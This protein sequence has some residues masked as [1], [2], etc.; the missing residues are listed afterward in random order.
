MVLLISCIDIAGLLLA[1]SA[2]RRREVATRLAISGSRGAMVEQL[3]V[4]VFS[5]VFVAVLWVSRSEVLRKH[6]ETSSMLLSPER[7]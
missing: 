2:W 7:G 6:Y 4:E 5:W 1:C 3:L